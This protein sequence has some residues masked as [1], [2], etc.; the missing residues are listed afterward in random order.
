MQDTHGSTLRRKPV[1][2]INLRAPGSD[3]RN[4]VPLPLVLLSGRVETVPWLLTIE[5]SPASTQMRPLKYSLPAVVSTGTAIE[6]VEMHAVL[7][8][9]ADEIELIVLNFVRG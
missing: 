8:L 3:R 4:D 1:F 7:M 2:A 9:L 5:K 6:N